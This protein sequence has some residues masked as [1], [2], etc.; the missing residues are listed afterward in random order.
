MQMLL[1]F[2]PRMELLI[3]DIGK[4]RWFPEWFISQN[5]VQYC[6]LQYSLLNKALIISFIIASNEIHPLPSGTR[7]FDAPKSP[8]TELGNYFVCKFELT[9]V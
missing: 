5:I 3:V 2:F 7:I 9:S 8:L 4:H 1:C 6:I